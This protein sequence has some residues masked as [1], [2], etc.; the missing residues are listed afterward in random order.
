MLAASPLTLP[1]VPD[2][3][4]VFTLSPEG[5]RGFR[6]PWG[7]SA[8]KGPADLLRW[9]LGT[10]AF[11][12]QRRRPP[13]LPVAPEPLAAWQA[14]GPGA[15]LMWLGHASWLVELDGLTVLIDPLFGRAA[16]APRAV[17]APLPVE[18]LPRVDAVLLTHGHYDHFDA[19]SL[20][21]LSRRFGAQLLVVLPR[22]LGRSLPAGLSGVELSWW[23]SVELAGVQIALVPAQHWHRRGAF[24]LDQSLWGGFV[25]KGSRSVYHSGDTGFFRGFQTIGRVFPGIDAAI[26][27]LG[28]FAPRWMMQ[29]QHMDPAESVMA[30][31][32]LGARHLL[33]MHWGTFDLTDEPLDHGPFEVLPAVVEA[34]G[35]DPRAMQVLAHGGVMALGEEPRVIGAAGVPGLG[36][37]GPRPDEPASTRKR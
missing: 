20:R 26:L 5:P 28:A 14:V 12:E 1:P 22:G 6:N 16:L 31:Q 33:G 3:E 15:R 25:L 11:A 13:R 27:P 29:Q 19:P 2:E 7:V 34:A 23:E 4:R 24:D 18:A 10:N 21:A 9:K 35:V 32:M 17:P 8:D 37:A 30:F 36:L